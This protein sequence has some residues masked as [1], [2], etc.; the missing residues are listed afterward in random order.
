MARAGFIAGLAG[1]RIAAGAA[2]GGWMRRRDSA[3]SGGAR[4]R[5][6]SSSAASVAS[7]RARSS[8]RSCTTNG[9]TIGPWSR[10][11]STSS[12]TA[13]RS[14]WRHRGNNGPVRAAGPRSSGIKRPALAASLWTHGICPHHRSNREK[15][16]TR[17]QTQRIAFGEF[18]ALRPPAWFRLPPDSSHPLQSM[19]DVNH[20]GGPTRKTHGPKGRTTRAISIDLWI[21]TFAGM[22][23]E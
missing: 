14:G 16:N 5:R 2:A 21:P 12:S 13:S 9:R 8:P 23:W 11:W 15:R 1:R 7:I 6:T 10:I 17:T 22:T 3:S 18:F 4:G 19:R 20:A